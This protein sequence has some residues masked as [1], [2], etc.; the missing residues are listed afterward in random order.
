MRYL[1]ENKPTH[2]CT[3]NHKPCQNL[4]ISRA[5]TAIQATNMKD[6]YK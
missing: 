2:I 6:K 4:L 1:T 5:H 3:I